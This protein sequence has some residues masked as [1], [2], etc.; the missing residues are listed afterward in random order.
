MIALPAWLALGI[1]VCATGLSLGTAAHAA[2]ASA[3]I[4]IKQWTWNRDAGWFQVTGELVN[5][6]AEAVGA[7]LQV[8]FRDADGRV[9]N[10]DESWPGGSRNIPSQGTSAFRLSSRAYV[11]AKNVSIR[12][13]NV[14]QWP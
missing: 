14:R 1:V 6:C 5:R 11:T 4:E 7:Q 10:I 3:D 13:I 8:T 9:V 12:V 2:C